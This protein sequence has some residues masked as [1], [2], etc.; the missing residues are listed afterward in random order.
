MLSISVCSCALEFRDLIY[1][2]D[3]C[4]VDGAIL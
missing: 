3:Y 4:T 2:S 1:R